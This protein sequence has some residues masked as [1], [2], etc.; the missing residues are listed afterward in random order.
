MGYIGRVLKRAAW[1]T[2][3]APPTFAG[4]WYGCLATEEQRSCTKSI[5]GSLPV[6]AEGGLLRF[7]RTIYSGLLVGIDY[8]YT[9]Y[10]L[11][12]QSEDYQNAI[13]MAHSRSAQ[14]I[15]NTCLRNGGLY[16]K[17]GQGL[18][19]MN[20]V[21]P[22]EYVDTLKVL[23]DQAL[24]RTMVGEVEQIFL[25]DFGRTQHELFAEFSSEPIAAASLAQVFR[26]KTHRGA[27]VA[28]KVQYI[29]LRDRFNSDVG[30]LQ[31]VL[32]IIQIIHTRFAFKWVLADLRQTLENELDFM[33]EAD[34]ARACAHQLAAFK[35][36]HVPSVEAELTSSRVLTTEFIDGVK[37]ND[38]SALASRGV[39][40][41]V[42]LDKKLLRIFSEQIFH[43]G[44]VHAD[45]HPGN[46][47]VRV[48]NGHP[49][50]VLI[51]HGLYE[52]MPAK[53]RSALCGLWVAVVENNYEDMKRYGEDLNVE[54]YRLFAMALTQRYIKPTKEELEKDILAQFID[55]QGP[56]KFSRK[57]FNKLPEMEQEKL[58][59]SIRD[60][61]D[62]MLDVFQRMPSKLVLVLRN[63]NTIRAII[64]EHGSGVERYREMARVAV[65]GR[66]GGGLRGT[67]AQA[68][69]DLR[70]A[71]DWVKSGVLRV[72]MRLALAMGYMPDLLESVAQN[73]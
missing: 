39:S 58:R 38:R 50:I 56:K 61:H 65:S 7:S 49:Q 32:D 4:A 42:D 2:A 67:L 9:L 55:K 60:F 57:E 24:R 6:V 21:L 53:L 27:D 72:G 71:W 59:E 11:D 28:V 10:G 54:D 43:T 46:L 20:H 44:F 48:V 51:D 41:L 12:E 33:K 1:I 26:A 19:S 25:Q 34:N 37:I 52:F 13:S 22:K 15:L 63:L 36:L 47:L 17:L 3:L 23:Q 45:P 64:K 18:L 14:R 29:D 8:K 40:S 62:R 31:C 16:I 5:L 70:L 69:F 30:T 68:A 66:L 73:G 35:Y